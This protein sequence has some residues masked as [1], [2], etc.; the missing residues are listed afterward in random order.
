MRAAR[1]VVSVFL[2][3]IGIVLFAADDA[4]YALP[5]TTV[6]IS[7]PGRFYH[8]HSC[9][10]IRNGN[11]TAI[12]VSNAREQGFYPCLKCKPPAW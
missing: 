11:P 3:A 9:V 2:L 8:R 4:M 10:V 7:R 5:F 6:Y 1:R 12:S